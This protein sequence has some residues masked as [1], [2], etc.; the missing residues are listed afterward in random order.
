MDEQLFQTTNSQIGIVRFAII[1]AAAIVA[2]AFSIYNFSE[3]N[4]FFTILIVV[5]LAVFFLSGPKTITIYKDHLSISNKGILKKSPLESK[6]DYSML[7]E[8]TADI[9][10]DV[11]DMVLTR[12]D[13]LSMRYRFVVLP[14]MKAAKSFW[15]TTNRDELRK[16]VELTNQLIKDST[17]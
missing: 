5:S 10:D 17:K 8:V 9:P 14:K 7:T 1:R 12:V 2:F 16:A 13:P 11:I 4:F 3:N 6:Y 15:I